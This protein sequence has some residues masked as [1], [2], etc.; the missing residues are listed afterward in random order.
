MLLAS[1]WGFRRGEAWL[2]WTLVTSG[3]VGYAVAI[4]VHHAVGYDN[5][6][7][8]APAYAGLA[9]VW[10]AAAASH[11]FLCGCHAPPCR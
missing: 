5:L 10:L 3:T 6:K 1:L 11:A 2:W 9:M 8:L 7:H 4:A